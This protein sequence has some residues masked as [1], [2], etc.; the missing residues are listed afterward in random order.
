MNYESLKEYLKTVNIQKK[1]TDLIKNF[2]NNN[3][4]EI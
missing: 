3:N 4:I 2:C 1:E